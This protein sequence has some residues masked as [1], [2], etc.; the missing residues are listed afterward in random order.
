[1]SLGL[2]P[3]PA[4]PLASICFSMRSFNWKPTRTLF[5]YPAT[6]QFKWK[7]GY[8]MLKVSNF[9]DF[10]LLSLINI[11]STILEK[12]ALSYQRLHWNS[13][14]DYKFH[15]YQSQTYLHRVQMWILFHHLCND[16]WL[17]LLLQSLERL[18]QSFW[19]SKF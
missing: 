16:L 15:I 12:S 4:F 13:T 14:F 11:N 17:L 6:L 8:M 2:T 10:W 3:K 7:H 9:L 5:N 1:M 18:L 19:Y